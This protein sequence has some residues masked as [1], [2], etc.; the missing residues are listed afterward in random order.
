[1]D[2]A[3]ASEDITAVAEPKS[4]LIGDDP[5]RISMPVLNN[6]SNTNNSSIHM[7]NAP[8]AVTTDENDEEYSQK[9]DSEEPSDDGQTSYSK[10]LKK[11]THKA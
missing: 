11:D 8:K 5:K 4:A 3:P 7:N 2:E 10:E 6:D 9:T 1:V